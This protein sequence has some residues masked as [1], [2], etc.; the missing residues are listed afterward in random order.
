PGDWLLAVVLDLGVVL[1]LIVLIAGTAALF[2][3]P[4][5]DVWHDVIAGPWGWTAFLLAAGAVAAW[6]W[7]SGRSIGPDGI[8]CAVISLAGFLAL[9]LAPGDILGWRTYHGM[10]AGQALAGVVLPLVAWQRAGLRLGAVAD[11][12]RAAV[13]RWST[14]ALGLVVLFAVRAYWSD[15]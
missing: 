4:L 8:G 7:T 6:G 14:I 1:T 5:P 9:G 13:V 11:E 2:V 15:P 12:V 10:L 3:H